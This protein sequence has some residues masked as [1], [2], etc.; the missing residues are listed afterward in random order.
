MVKMEEKLNQRIPVLGNQ[1]LSD[2]REYRDFLMA[3]PD[4]KIGRPHSHGET[5]NTR[6]LRIRAISIA[7]TELETSMKRFED[8]A[9]SELEEYYCPLSE[10]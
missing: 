5:D 3:L 2:M 4:D 1:L 6:G 7:I 8:A 9:N 10:N